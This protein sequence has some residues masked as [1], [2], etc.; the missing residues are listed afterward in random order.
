VISPELQERQKQFTEW[1]ET[2]DLAQA[3]TEGPRRL[4]AGRAQAEYE[5]APLPEGF[6]ITCSFSL[7]D[8]GMGTPW[9]SGTSRE[10]CI[11]YFLGLGRR[12]F[13][14]NPEM[15]RLLSADTLFGWIE[16]NVD[17]GQMQSRAEVTAIIK[18]HSPSNQ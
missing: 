11:E 6:A 12:F 5:I 4:A 9:I 14:Q 15:L 1:C 18:A 2:R 17:Q 13:A 7:P 10:E 8:S 3:A 16:P